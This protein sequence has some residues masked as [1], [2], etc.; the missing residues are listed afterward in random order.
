MIDKKFDDFDQY[1][2]TLP[3]E[4]QYTR[5]LLTQ[6]FNQYKK[7]LKYAEKFKKSNFDAVMKW[8]SEEEIALLLNRE[9]ATIE[10]VLKSN[11]LSKADKYV[12]QAV[13][14]EDELVSMKYECQKLLNNSKDKKDNPD[15]A[16]FAIPKWCHHQECAY[17]YEKFISN[18]N[19]NI[20]IYNKQ[21]DGGESK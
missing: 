2:N 12:L 18:V 19:V 4:F 10:K 8:W 11:S 3:K 14:E 6:L 13:T 15:K 21:K 9:I 20:R 1:I 5:F 7:E 16:P 17:G